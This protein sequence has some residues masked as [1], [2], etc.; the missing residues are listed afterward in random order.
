MVRSRSPGGSSNA[1]PA[2]ADGAP[3]GTGHVP[4]AGGAPAGT[5]RIPIRADRLMF[6]PASESW[7]LDREAYLLLGAGP[8]ALLMQ[9]AHP[10][11]AE[12]VA[13]H[14]RFREDP[15]A[16]LIGTLRSYLGI[17]FGTTDEAQAELERL[18][19][20]HAHVLGPVRD[21]RAREITGADSYEAGDPELSLW[22][23]ATLVDSTL[24]AYEAWGAPL[25]RVERE[26]FYAETL[27][28]GRAFGIP[29]ELLPPDLD[30][31]DRYLGRMLGPSGVVHV[32]P[33]ARELA[34]T[35]IHPPLPPMALSAAPF[36]SRVPAAAYDWAMWPA[37][38]LLPASLREE[39]GLATPRW[40]RVTASWIVAVWRFGRL[41]APPALRWMPWALRADRRTAGAPR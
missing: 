19:R 29:D 17:V 21:E 30:A 14:S 37:V 31:F 28:L 15:W 11:V 23:H 22:V 33:T 39:Y 5:D 8:R 9:L 18:A 27:S 12:G 38:E 40:R 10:L 1:V 41:L 24:V 20:L 7:R 36:L 26:R 25:G 6:G 35:I 34:G 3:A 2:S 13:Q 32:T 16:R 4:I